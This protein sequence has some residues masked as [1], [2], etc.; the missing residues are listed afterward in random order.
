MII[1]DFQ[2]VIQ[3]NYIYKCLHFSLGF[4]MILTFLIMI[5][6]KRK[7]HNDMWFMEPK[8]RLTK[9]EIT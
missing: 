4:D 6:P 9:N 8:W 5:A 3:Y 2:M 7:T 1:H